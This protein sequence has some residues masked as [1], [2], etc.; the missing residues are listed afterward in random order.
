MSSKDEGIANIG[1][2]EQLETYFTTDLISEIVPTEFHQNNS[3]LFKLAR[4][5]K[6]YEDAIR[7]DAT[8]RELEF[9]FDRW[10]S[11]A[12]AF[13]RLGL[14]RDD[15]YAEFLEVYSY[16]HTGLN[17]ELA[18]GRAKAAPLPEMQGF[19]DERI[20]LLAAICRE[21]Q[22][23]TGAEPF[24]LPTRMLGRILGIHYS[25]V[26][27]LLRVLR[28]LQIIHL[29][30][31]EVHRGGNRCPRYYYGKHVRETETSIVARSPASPRPPPTA[32]ST[33]GHNVENLNPSGSDELSVGRG[34]VAEW[35][36]RRSRSQTLEVNTSTH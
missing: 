22:E 36:A 20:R 26:A 18:V 29:A 10:C 11:L 5:M 32:N 31:G 24:F 7:R 21:M 12:R 30:N 34:Y 13:W 28:V 8:R 3:S 35:L 23:I 27:R 14:T 17:I 6:S 16:A 2:N 25:H 15:Y 1:C 4:L 9:V 19:S 33:D